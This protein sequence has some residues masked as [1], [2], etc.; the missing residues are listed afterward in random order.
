[1]KRETKASQRAIV[2][3]KARAETV[4]TYLM[5][6]LVDESTH[7]ITIEGVWMAQ[8]AVEASEAAVKVTEAILA[9]TTTPKSTRLAAIDLADARA[10]KATADEVLASAFTWLRFVEWTYRDLLI[11]RLVGLLQVAS[12]R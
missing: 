10:A 2:A 6:G 1:M 9:D 5:M 4:Y 12:R 11:G 7:E 8:A 3:A